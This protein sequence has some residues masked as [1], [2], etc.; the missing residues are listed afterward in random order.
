MARVFKRPGSD[1]YYGRFKVNGKDKWFST[2]CTG[3][4]QAQDVANGKEQAAR[5]KINTSDYFTGLMALLA[6]LPEKEQDAQRNEFAR[7]LM[8]GQSSTLPVAD[9]W[10]A[11]LDSPLKGNPGQVT[12]GHYDAMWRRFVKWIAKQP[13]KYLHEITE[14]HAQDYIA[15]LWKSKVAPRTFN[16]HTKFLKSMFRVLRVKAGLIANVW[17]N[18]KSMDKETQGRQNFTPEELKTICSKAQ[19]TIRYMIGIGLYTGM[20]MGDVVNLKWANIGQDSIVLIPS[21]TKRKGKQI[22][23]PIH[24]VL[25]VLLEELRKQSGAGEYLFPD[26]HAVFLKDNSAISKL[27]QKFLED[28][29]I[30]TS[31]QGGIHRRKVITRK[32]FHSLRHSFVSL[33]A[34]NRVPQVAIQEL[35]GHGS[36][37]MTALYSHADFEQKQSAINSLPAMVF[38]N[39]GPKGKD[40]I[41]RPKPVN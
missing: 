9:A 21:K 13:V 33:C 17:D 30:A 8:Q 4:K 37:A 29:G 19:G 7:R 1:F 10:Q 6:R 24:P 39:N 40:K 31:E 2:K 27:F 23:L 15:D 16:G 22:T 32:G 5:A 28:C 35:V 18:I 11:W 41:S 12:I 25:R 36:P 20:R 38:E 26:D 34:A 3:R 14:T